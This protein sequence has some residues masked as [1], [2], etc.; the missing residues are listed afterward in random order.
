[1]IDIA[2]DQYPLVAQDVHHSF[3]TTGG[4]ILALAG[5]SLSIRN[6][7]FVAVVGPSGC[8]KTTLLRLLAGLLRPTR[9]NILFR[10]QPLNGPRPE[11]G[12]V[13]QQPT[14]LPWR[15]ALDNVG[16]PLEIRHVARDERHR[17]AQTLLDMVG[18]AG[19]E[20]RQPRELSG[21]MQQRVAIAR[22]LAYD[23]AIMLMDE[24]FGALDALTREQM[25]LELLRLWREH[26]RT[27]VLVTHSISE[28]VFLAD[29]VLVLTHR[30]GH[31]AAE[32][33]VSLPRPRTLGM[34]GTPEFAMISHQVR[35]AISVQESGS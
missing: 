6:G 8:G 21:G 22:A 2:D 27:V 15:S 33:V 31:I 4:H 29:R 32:V 20:A 12:F 16:L 35:R 19:F 34:M 24:P 3:E 9:G 28:A 5:I 14:L 30:P 18:L 26:R 10:G 25:N 1:M 11:I 23:P 7:E 13:F 17:R